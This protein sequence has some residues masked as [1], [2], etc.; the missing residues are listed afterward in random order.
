VDKRTIERFD[1]VVNMWLEARRDK[2]SLELPADPLKQ[3]AILDRLEHHTSELDRLFWLHW[4]DMRKAL[5]AP[6]KTAKIPLT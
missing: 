1:H 6:H 3:Q 4:K 5:L 2:A